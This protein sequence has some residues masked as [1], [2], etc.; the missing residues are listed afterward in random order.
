MTKHA[1]STHWSNRQ[2]RTVLWGMRVLFAIYRLLGRIPFL[3]ALGP[4]ILFYWLSD[5]QLRATSLDYLQRAHRQGLLKKAPDRWMTLAHLMR[6]ADTILDKMVALS[7]QST[8]DMIR[9]Q[10]EDV[11]LDLVR[12]KRGCV[13]MTSHMG[14]I[15][16]LQ[17]YGNRLA[18]VPIHILIHTKHSSSFNALLDELNPLNRLTFTEVSELTPAFTFQ[19]QEAIE[20]GALLFVA[21]DRVPIRSQATVSVPFLGE[22]AAFPVGGPILANLFHCPLVQMTCIRDKELPKGTI[23]RF[24]RYLVR[25]KRL[26]DAV[27][28]NRRQRQHDMQQLIQA[29]AQELECA[30]ADS[31]L[32][33]FNFYP[34][35][36]SQ[37][38]EGTHR[39]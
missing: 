9:V 15:E 34:F 5:P 30:I 12:Q 32:D 6:F 36:H 2:E 1:D 39:D 4:V 16:A 14:C 26:S 20:Q 22:E 29:Y 8:N 11:L 23:H 7:G 31:P 38:T 35:W 27:Y 3:I 18:D 37:Q 13:V 10:G 28:L 21:G 19:M 33:W 24:N 25:F 17:A